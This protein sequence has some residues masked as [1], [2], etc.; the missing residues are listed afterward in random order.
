MITCDMPLGG[1]EDGC[2]RTLEHSLSQ[3]PLKGEVC[4][5]LKITI[6]TD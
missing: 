1:G 2:K 6:V 4:H 5:M 3:A